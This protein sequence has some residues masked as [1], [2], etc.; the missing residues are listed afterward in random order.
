MPNALGGFVPLGKRC[1]EGVG[2]RGSGV[3][4]WDSIMRITAS[5]TSA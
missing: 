4:L 3:A 2:G 1:A 5:A